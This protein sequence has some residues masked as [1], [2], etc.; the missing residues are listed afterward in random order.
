MGI[1]AVRDI[2]QLCI[3]T[4]IPTES[5]EGS[6]V[7]GRQILRGVYAVLYYGAQNHMLSGV[8]SSTQRA[9]CVGASHPNAVEVLISLLPACVLVSGQAYSELL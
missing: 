8:E 2:R 9:R 7:V 6:D 4:L 1:F 3:V 5:G